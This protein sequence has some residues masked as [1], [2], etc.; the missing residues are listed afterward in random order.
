M[1]ISTLI[2]FAIAAAVIWLGVIAHSAKP[3]M[4]LDA[5]AIILVLGGTVAAGLIAFPFSKFIDLFRFIT[6]G[7]LYPQK[8]AHGK[9]VEEIMLLLADQ[10]VKSEHRAVGRTSHPLLAE[11]CRL[12]Q[13]GEL[14]EAEF[15]Q[16]LLQRSQRF[17]ERYLSD[18]KT[19]N[20]LA[21]FPPAFGLLGAT[22]G[23]ISMMT[24]LGASG[25]DSI[26]PSMAIALVATFWGIAVANMVLLPLSDHATKLAA[27]DSQLRT[28][29]T[30]GLVLLNRR[31]SPA[32]M[33]EHMIGFLP[34]KD[35]D[36]TKWR[37]LQAQVEHTISHSSGSSN[38]RQTAT[39][40]KPFA[41]TDESPQGM[42]L[43]RHDKKASGDR[44]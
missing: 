6:T 8:R 27:D 9:I 16:V 44:E 31:V 7:V 42:R 40:K 23:M 25:Q 39:G 38:T 2:G 19:L 18:A 1:N 11:G 17:K 34:V 26:G 36:D 37:Q 41:H 20:A 10:H 5:H 13:K 3:T 24:N 4:F 12:M 43:V 29:I 28:L 14:N 30:T 22:T 32:V 35:R 15:K 21:K 33:L